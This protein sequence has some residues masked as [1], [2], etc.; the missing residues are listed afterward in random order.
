MMR[1]GR[2]LAGGVKSFIFQRGR[3]GRDSSGDLSKVPQWVWR[4]ELPAPSPELFP[5]PSRCAVPGYPCYEG[6]FPLGARELESLSDSLGA[7][8]YRGRGQGAVSG[9]EWPRASAKSL[10]P[11][12]PWTAHLQCGDSTTFLMEILWAPNIHSPSS[13][14][15]N[16]Y[17]LSSFF[18]TD[19]TPGKV[20]RQLGWMRPK[21]GNSNF[22][23]TLDLPDS[24][25]ESLKTFSPFQCAL[26]SNFLNVIGFFLLIRRNN[27]YV[28]RSK[29]CHREPRFNVLPHLPS[30]EPGD[31]L[32]KRGHVR[33]DAPWR[34]KGA[35]C[36]SES[37]K[38]ES[39]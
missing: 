5:S 26:P 31:H 9:T 39:H 27:K 4:A 10:F 34:Q 38:K 36:S 17:S 37:G 8:C 3:T 24:I 14:L 22:H 33:Q 29:W 28:F 18:K 16:T 6:K 2:G 20:E 30:L 7:M 12:K 32:Q 11:S 21:A 1:T 19:V 35:W 15:I 13:F 25:W 23:S